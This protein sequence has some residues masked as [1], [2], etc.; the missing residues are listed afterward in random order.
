MSNTD[1][2][3][4]CNS[5]SSSPNTPPN[6]YSSTPNVH[7]LHAEAIS[8]KPSPVTRALLE[9]LDLMLIQSNINLRVDINYDHDLHFTPVSGQK[10][11]KKRSG[12]VHC[13]QSRAYEL[14]AHACNFPTRGTKCQHTGLAISK[15]SGS[16][17]KTLFTS[18]YELLIILVPDREHDQ[19]SQFRDIPQLIQEAELGLLDVVHL[20][21]LI[22]KLLLIH[23][24]PMRDASIQEIDTR[25][26]EENE[27]S[28]A[29]TAGINQVLAILE[30]VKLD[31]TNHQIRTLRYSLVQ[32]TTSDGPRFPHIQACTK[33][34]Q[35]ARRQRQQHGSLP[36]N[37]KRLPR[38]RSFLPMIINGNCFEAL[39][40]TRSSS[41]MM[42]EA[43]ANALG[44]SI[45]RAESRRH[46]FKNA[47][48]ELFHS[49]GEATTQVSFPGEGAQECRFAVLRT[50]AAPLIMGDPFLRTT[51]TLTKFRHRLKKATTSATRR[52]WQVCYMSVPS[53]RLEC[54]LDSMSVQADPD[55]GSDMDLISLAYA[56]QSGWKINPLPPEI[57]PI[58]LANGTRKTLSGYVHVP[59]TIGGYSSYNTFYVLDGLVCDVILGDETLD[60]LDAFNQYAAYFVELEANMVE[61]NHCHNINWA[62]ERIRRTEQILNGVYPSP[63]H[64]T[65]STLPQQQQIPK[66]SSWRQRLSALVARQSPAE[67]AQA[68]DSAF[69]S[70]LEILDNVEVNDRD[71]AEQQMSRLSGDTLD[72]A[73]DTNR[74]RQQKHAER[75]TAIKAAR[76]RF[77]G[78][79]APL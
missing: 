61:P 62:E 38:E 53:Q 37:T 16:G 47:C 40:D 55:T 2:G 4:L 1:S 18:L 27:D 7:S 36:Y 49:V 45:D 8:H 69:M 13:W 74:A 77:F 11:E 34:V 31:V 19:I 25:F 10:G 72:R 43:V 26:R 29:Y 67:D 17:L 60:E 73:K 3:A 20:G 76:D 59:F 24:A 9:E 30:A 70:A 41:N 44:I 32:D 66:R 57:G 79:P 33:Q 46:S 23:C 22:C 50:C 52:A 64:P 56:T 65:S 15:D 35:V 78:V 42:T 14:L 68:W 48:G 51:E 12:A 39:P 75:T 71:Q 5:P 54:Y 6:I 21:R 58:E 28:T 63:H